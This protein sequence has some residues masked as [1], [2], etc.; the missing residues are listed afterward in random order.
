MQ[1]QRTLKVLIG[2]FVGVGF[3]LSFLANE[4]NEFSFQASEIRWL[5]S[6]KDVPKCLFSTIAKVAGNPP[7]VIT[8]QSKFKYGKGVKINFPLGPH[9]NANF[10]IPFYR[11]IMYA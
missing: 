8:S 5:H 7:L 6:Q 4:Y 1:Y 11:Y 3:V 10:I 9:F 2:S